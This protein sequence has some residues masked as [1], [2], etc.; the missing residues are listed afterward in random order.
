MF[1]FFASL[2]DLFGQLGLFAV[3]LY[4]G[5]LSLFFS[6]WS[7]QHTERFLLVTLIMHMFNGSA[8]Q[9][10]SSSVCAARTQS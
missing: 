1:V 6:H 8:A 7:E 9:C 10:V 5:L 2:P 4:L 3:L